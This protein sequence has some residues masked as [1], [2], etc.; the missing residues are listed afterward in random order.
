MQPV[1][2][3]TKDHASD[4]I[5]LKLPMLSHAGIDLNEM[6]WVTHALCRECNEE[7]I[8]AEG[9]HVLLLGSDFVATCTKGHTTNPLFCEG[10]G[11]DG[12]SP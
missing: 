4:Y 9:E 3:R 1:L 6:V 8:R 10:E 7:V 11:S 12:S 2:A 5:M